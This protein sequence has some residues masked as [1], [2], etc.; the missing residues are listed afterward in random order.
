MQVAVGFVILTV[1]IV[2]RAYGNPGAGGSGGW[3][4]SE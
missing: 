4:Y 1:R 3:V 2:G